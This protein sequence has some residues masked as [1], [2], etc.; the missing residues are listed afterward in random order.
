ME[1]KILVVDDDLDLLDMTSLILKKDGHN[2]ITLQDSNNIVNEVKKAEPDVI[3]L[4]LWMPGVEGDEAINMLRHDDETKSIPVILFSA[5]PR[6]H[7]IAEELN[8]SFLSKPFDLQELR[9]KLKDI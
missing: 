4:D 8:V 3:L 2:V 7:K 6:L 9:Q 5:Y 1:K